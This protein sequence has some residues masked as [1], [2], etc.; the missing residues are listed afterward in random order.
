LILKAEMPNEP[1]YGGLA[2]AG[3]P[4]GKTVPD[5]AMAG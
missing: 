1:L 2:R 3:L 4:S 5:R